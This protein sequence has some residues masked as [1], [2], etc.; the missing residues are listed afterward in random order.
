[1]YAQLGDIRFKGAYS[2]VSKELEESA[3]Y[4]EHALIGGKPKLQRTGLAADTLKLN[5]KLHVN[6][7][8]PETEIDRLRNYLRGGRNVR[9]IT[10]SGKLVGNFVITSLKTSYLHQGEA[11]K[12]IEADLEVSLLEN[13]LPDTS[14][15]AVLNGFAM[16]NNNPLQALSAPVFLPPTAQ[17]AQSTVALNVGTTALQQQVAEAQAN[18]AS[19]QDQ[20]RQM[21]NTAGG[22]VNDATAAITAVNETALDVFEATRAFE[23]DAQQMLTA[24]EQFRTAAQGGS[25]QDAIAALIPVSNANS[26]LLTSAEVLERLN[27]QRTPIPTI[28]G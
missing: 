18:P 22:M 8:T 17:A 9:Y 23:L 28:N 19:L 25:L 3:V 16:S 15:A 4:A 2:P 14:S 11:G 12:I 5:M 7:C 6:F 24:V 10:G 21:T 26:A 13:A 1:M 20:L 27:G